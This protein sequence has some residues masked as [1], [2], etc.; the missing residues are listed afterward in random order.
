[1][2]SRHHL[3]TPEIMSKILDLLGKEGTPAVEVILDTLVGASESDNQE[4]IKL[5][6]KDEKEYYFPANVRESIETNPELFQAKFSAKHG[7][8]FLLPKQG[9]GGIANATFS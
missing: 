3:N 7:K 4:W 6:T 8:Y 2:Y 5:T 9:S 1:M